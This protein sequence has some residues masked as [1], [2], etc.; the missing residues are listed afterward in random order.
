MND[1]HSVGYWKLLEADRFDSGIQM[2]L[3]SQRIEACLPGAYSKLSMDDYFVWRDRSIQ[4]INQFIRDRKYSNSQPL[5]PIIDSSLA[6]DDK[7]IL[8]RA[9]EKWQNVQAKDQIKVRVERI[10]TGYSLD[11]LYPPLVQYR[12]VLDQC[13]TAQDSHTP[14]GGSR[15][16]GDIHLTF[17][18]EASGKMDPSSY[19]GTFMAAAHNREF[20]DCL[21]TPFKQLVFPPP[22]DRLSVRVNVLYQAALPSASSKQS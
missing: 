11:D 5:D 18:I 14:Y 2:Q 6:C 19:D 1:I 22:K 7:I 4:N 21:S 13:L 17:T 16:W 12:S 20:L 10:P 3:V 15:P 8:E 9:Q